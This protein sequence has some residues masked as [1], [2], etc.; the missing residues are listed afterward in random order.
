MAVFGDKSERLSASIAGL[1]PFHDF[2]TKYSPVM[3][4]KCLSKSSSANPR[5][6]EG[7]GMCQNELVWKHCEILICLSN[8]WVSFNKSRFWLVQRSKDCNSWMKLTSYSSHKISRTT[9]PRSNTPEGYSLPCQ[10]IDPIEPLCFSTPGYMSDFGN[11]ISKTSW[12]WRSALVSPFSGMV[13]SIDRN[14]CQDW[15]DGA[16]NG[17]FATHINQ[18]SRAQNH[19]S[20]YFAAVARCMNRPG[21][22]NM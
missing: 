20:M 15:F 4:Q 21:S 6:L 19:D 11:I 7:I 8:S 5:F 1:S 14:V 9:F 3:N 18:A 2:M 10:T 16:K 13:L 22:G 17:S 12:Q